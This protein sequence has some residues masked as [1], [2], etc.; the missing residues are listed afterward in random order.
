[1]DIKEYNKKKRYMEVISQRPI[2]LMDYF[3]NLMIN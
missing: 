3:V 2:N 1:M